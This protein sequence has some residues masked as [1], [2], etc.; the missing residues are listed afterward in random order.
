MLSVLNKEHHVKGK[1][2][3]PFPKV[4]EYLLPSVSV[5]LLE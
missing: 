3:T 1:K 5:Y 2:K 4:T